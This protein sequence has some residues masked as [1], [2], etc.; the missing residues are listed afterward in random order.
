MISCIHVP[1]MAICFLLLLAMWRFW[2]CIDRMGFTQEV[3]RRAPSLVQRD[4]LATV[5]A[6]LPFVIAAIDWLGIT[7]PRQ[8][9]PVSPYLAVFA[10]LACLG[11]CVFVLNNSGERFSGTLVGTRESALRTIAMLRIISA[12]ELAHA[13]RYLE[14]HEKRYS[15]EVASVA[16]HSM[17]EEQK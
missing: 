4:L 3:G 16:D 15:Y 2:R 12:A 8:T 6:L 9:E 10:S 1:L 14:A 11:G 7:L 17:R 5:F 13:L